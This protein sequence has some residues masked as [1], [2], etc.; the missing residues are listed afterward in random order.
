MKDKQY[1]STLDIN[2]AVEGVKKAIINSKSLLSD[3]ILL[4]ENERYSRS[5][6]LAILA[7]EE[8]GKPA[9]IRA[10]MLEEDAGELKK[11]WQK[12]R[13][14]T[15]KNIAWIL[16]LL[17]SKGANTA[18][19]MNQIFDNKSDHSY[20]LDNIKQLAFYTDAFSNCKWS[21][22]E[23]AID[24]ELAKELLS[25]AEI[26]VGKDEKHSM[27]SEEE[28]KLWVK[29][30]KPVWKVDDGL[31]RE[32]LIKCYFEAEELGYIELGMA[33]KMNDFMK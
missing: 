1:R 28:L 21:I 11:E 9:I 26:L 8:A 4:F 6:A 20:I 12:Y 7:I 18:N 3:A 19:D 23:Q 14:H 32:A 33:H 25:V 30:M 31:M 29:H 13:R 24:K 22:P 17:A 5:A 10:I 16:P 27:C 2:Q 15:S